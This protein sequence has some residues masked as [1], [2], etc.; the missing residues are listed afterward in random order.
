MRMKVVGIMSGT[1]LDGVDL[2][3]VNFEEKGSLSF[4]ILGAETIPY[5]NI[6]KTKLKN[7]F[8]MNAEQ[9]LKL[10]NEYGEYLGR[11]CKDFLKKCNQ[12]TE[13]IASHGHTVFHQPGS[14][15]TFQLGNGASIA[16]I[17]GITTVC[18]F[19]SL[20]VACGGQGAPLVPIGDRLLFSEYDYCLNL[21]GIA[22][23][24]FEKDQK[25][26]AFDCCPVNMILNK[27][28]NEKQ[29]DYDKDGL[30]AA[31][32]NL[33]QELLNRLNK[34]G[35]YHHS[36]PKSLG[37]EW[38]SSEFLPVVEQYS[39]ATEDK[40]HTVC[41]HIAYQ[42]GNCLMTSVSHNSKMLVTGGGA[43]NSFLADLIRQY[44]K[45]QIVIPEEIIIDFKEALIFALLGYLRIKEKDN[46]LSS[47]TGAKENSAGG[48]V[49][50]M[51]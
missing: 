13:L 41:H 1:S 39:I 29:L 37:A 6:W 49:Y 21:G 36:Y 34:L 9:F 2:A 10:H 23:I 33:H 28:A 8:F 12:Q 30:L 50:L 26:I 35:Y 20:D 22:N 45:V 11:L 18:D 32:G 27:L 44:C 4:Q 24:S 31:K 15:F 51:K 42:I 14:R 48:A 7:A 43:K 46:T 17:S 19:R 5:S 25:R 16:A 40:L 3:L 47:V 38:F